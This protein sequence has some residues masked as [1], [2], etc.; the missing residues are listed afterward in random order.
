[1]STQANHN[2]KRSQ[3]GCLKDSE[4]NPAS[5]ELKSVDYEDPNTPDIAYTYDRLG[6]IAAVTDATGSR[7]FAYDPD[8]L[9]LDTET[10]DK[11]F[12]SGRVLQ[13][14]Y[15]TGAETNGLPDATPDTLCSTPGRGE[16]VKR[17][18]LTLNEAGGTKVSES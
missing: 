16:G 9:Q 17:N 13:R 14:S 12:Y 8:T 6:R 3:T 4:K 11:T 5:G 7:S 15:Q 18:T 1:M 2:R 10:L